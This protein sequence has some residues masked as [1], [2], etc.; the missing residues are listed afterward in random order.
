MHE[1]SR[2]LSCRGEEEGEGAAVVAAEEEEPGGGGGKS[3]CTSSTHHHLQQRHQSCSSCRGKCLSHG[4]VGKVQETCTIT[5]L[6]QSRLQGVCM[7]ECVCSGV[8][9]WR[10]CSSANTVH[11]S[12]LE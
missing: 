1:D 10:N 5:T 8:H 3:L 7:C 12:P 2:N 6:L 11:F 9:G 4:E